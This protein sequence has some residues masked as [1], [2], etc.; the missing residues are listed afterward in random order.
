MPGLE[1]GWTLTWQPSGY[2]FTKIAICFV[3]VQSDNGSTNAD[4][5]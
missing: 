4:T 5:V 2:I 1:A 3:A